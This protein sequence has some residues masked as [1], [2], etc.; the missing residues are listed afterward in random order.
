MTDKFLG[1]GNIGANISNGTVSIYGSKIGA[2]NLDSSRAIKTDSQGRLQTTDLDIADVNNLQSILDNVL[3]NPYT[4]PI[5]QQFVVLGE[6]KSTDL[7]TNTYFSVNDELQKIDNLTASTMDNTNINGTLNVEY[8][9]SDRIYNNTK[10]IYIELDTDT[11]NIA[12]SELLFNGN[13]VISTPYLGTLESSAIATGYI[14]DESKSVRMTID[15][16]TFNV[17]APFFQFNGNK[18]VSTPFP[19]N[20]EAQ[21]FITTGG[22][23]TQYTMGDG[24]LLTYSANSGNSNFYLYKN[25]ISV[26]NVPQVGFIS[27]NN[28]IQSD[29]TFIYINYLTTDGIDIQVFFKQISQLTDIY[30]QDKLN[31]A[32]FI[33]YN[34]TATP[35]ITIN[36]RISIA[37]L[38]HSYGGTGFE[39]F[40]NNTNLLVSFFTNAIEVDTRLSSLETKTQYQT[41]LGGSIT[42]FTGN[43]LVTS[44]MQSGTIRKTGGLTSQFLKANGD[45][46]SNTYVQG[47]AT[48]INSSVSYINNLGKVSSNVSNLYVQLGEN[49]IQ[50]AVTAIGV[51][52]NIQCSSGGS[53]ENIILNKQNYTL[54]GANCPPFGQTTQIN[55]NVTIGDASVLS[56]RIRMKDMKIVG[57]LTFISSI[58]NE[59]RTFIDNCD[60]SGTITF[61]AV[62]GQFEFYSIT[63]TG[64]SFTTANPIVIPDQNTY[65]LTFSKCIFF[66]QTITNNLTLAH[67]SNLLFETCSGLSTLSLGNCVKVGNLITQAGVI[68][69]FSS[70]LSLAGSS[71]S[72]VKYDGSSDSNTYAKIQA[73]SVPVQVSGITETSLSA[74]VTKGSWTWADSAIGALKIIRVTGTYTRSTAVSNTYTFRIKAGGLTVISFVTA[75]SPNTIAIPTPFLTYEL[76]FELRRVSNTQ[77]EMTSKYE[78][79]ETQQNPNVINRNYNSSTTNVPAIGASTLWSLTCQGTSATGTI[80]CTAIITSIMD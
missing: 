32:N 62:A 31:S 1:T 35:I 47:I 67:S 72:F 51:G 33:Q 15:T 21:K 57:N 68:T 34:V 26:S 59:L 8:I 9:S 30:I 44:E 66:G 40:G 56:T 22:T 28:Q 80:F 24:S 75:P 77:I 19:S 27:Y 53:T 25:Q 2:R 38:M 63:F 69:Q 43:L 41:G 58:N 61:P 46:D 71:T 42:G 36:S 17:N 49:T 14:Y 65:R 6:I 73:Y 20:L 50:S 54:C 11:I 76:Q 48:Q 10:S 78:N 23:N 60:F 5:G 39:S 29:A 45:V 70:N 37:V 52:Y 4:P 74:S 55:G 64:C 3:S 12:A 13:D 7:E 18:V 79:I 16:S